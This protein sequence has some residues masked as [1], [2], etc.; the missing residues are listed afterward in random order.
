MAAAS[1]QAGSVT[2]R[3]HEPIAESWSRDACRHE[4]HVLRHRMLSRRSA[5]HYCGHRYQREDPRQQPER[6]ANANN[7]VISTPSSRSSPLRAATA[8]GIAQITAAAATEAKI[9]TGTQITLTGVLDVGADA[10]NTAAGS[11][12][13]GSFGIINGVVMLSTFDRRR[14][15]RRDGRPGAWAR[16]AQLHAHATNGADAQHS[17]SVFPSSAPLWR[18]ATATVTSEADAEAAIGARVIVSTGKSPST[19]H[20][21]NSRAPT[22]KAALA[23]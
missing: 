2:L 20:L 4:R 19:R 14:H 9:G 21:S 6:R 10:T 8:Q 23:V 12:K 11:A 15:D 16:A 13:G 18:S 3:G 22:S 1:R 5:A 17:P 7:Q